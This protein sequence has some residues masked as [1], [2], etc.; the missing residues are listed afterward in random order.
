[1]IPLFIDL[2][3]R[4]IVI[5]GGGEVAA[6]KAAYFAGRAAVDIVSRSFVTAFDRLDVSRIN[7]DIGPNSGSNL[8][9]YLDGAFLVI[10]AT[11]DPRINNEIG[12]ICRESE[13]LFNNA[14]G[15]S[16]DVILPAIAAGKN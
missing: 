3:G 9:T 14:D 11:S 2:T 10:A 6:R 7:A 4:R 13:I 15:E 5:F 16:G 8:K 12:R 1:M